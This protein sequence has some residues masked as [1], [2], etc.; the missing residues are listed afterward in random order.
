MYNYLIMTKRFFQITAALILT[1]IFFIA[2]LAQ[3]E[4]DPV[5]GFYVTQAK[6]AFEMSELRSQKMH[7]TFLVSSYYQQIGRGG[8]VERLDT[9]ITRYFM[10]GNRID[11]TQ[12]VAEPTSEMPDPTFAF[13]NIFAESYIYNFFPNDVGEENIAI[14]FDTP[15]SEDSLPAGLAVIDR[16]EYKLKRLYLYYQ[17]P[18][19]FKRLTRSYL[20]KEQ[21]G[22]I[23]ADSIWELNAKHGVFSTEYFR[24]DTDIGPLQLIR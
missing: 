18:D 8:I 11:S 10:T 15:G 19:G 13:P 16:Q 6:K 17:N 5:L 4:T 14:G 12:V 3:E 22:F 7:F 20:L 24:L 1:S 2:A 23:F 21:N 9:A